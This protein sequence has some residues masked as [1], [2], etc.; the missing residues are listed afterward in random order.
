MKK[1][2]IMVFTT[3]EETFL[4]PNEK[5]ILI[6]G[7]YKMQIVCIMKKFGISLSIS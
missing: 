4:S 5:K 7:G 6:C 1:S 3:G 2:E